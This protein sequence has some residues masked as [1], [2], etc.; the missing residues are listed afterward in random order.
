MIV[1]RPFRYRTRWMSKWHTVTLHHIITVYNNMFN[2][3]DGIMQPLAEKN[4]HWKENLFFAM[5]FARQKL[6]KYYTEVTP[7]TDMLPISAHILE[8][9]WKLRSFRKWDKG[10]DITRDEETDYTTQ[11]PEAL[12]TYVENEYCAEHRYLADIKPESILI[13][14]QF[15]PVTDW[16]Y[17]QSLCNPSD[18]SSDDEVYLTP[19]VSNGS[20]PSP[21]VRLWV[22]NEL[23]PNWWF[24]LWIQPN[25]QFG[26]GSMVNSQ[27][28]WIE[29]VV[30]GSIWGFIYCS[31]FCSLKI[32][33]YENRAFS[34]EYV[35]LVCFAVCDIDYF[36]ICIFPFIYCIL[37]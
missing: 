29:R 4:T 26:Y 5:K 34:S 20:G 22:G 12:L 9:I 32:V 13:N 33:Y 8:P 19:S 23:V 25:S 36:G 30:S 18:L 3:M 7:M 15:S 1:S 10:M 35:V 14:N 17:S 11:F 16:T 27:S 31:C 28:I 24:G 2:H 6:S 21:R 37:A